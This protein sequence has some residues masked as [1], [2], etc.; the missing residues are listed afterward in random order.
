M[1]SKTS[2]LFT[3]QLSVD[4]N[5]LCFDESFTSKT[6]CAC[7]MAEG[8]IATG[9]LHAL[10]AMDMLGTGF[11]FTKQSR[12][13]PKPVYVGD[14]IRAEPTYLSVHPRR[15]MAEVSFN[16]TNQ[17]GEEVLRGEATVFQALP[18]GD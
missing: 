1:D 9:L 5:P 16:A 3:T 8:G 4:Y 7:L 15:P 18:G 12:T 6:R 14:T 17:D 2:H 10:V 13:F 11:V